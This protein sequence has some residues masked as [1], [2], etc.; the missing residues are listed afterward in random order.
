MGGSAG[1]WEHLLRVMHALNYARRAKKPV[2]MSVL[3][4]Q[5]SVGL[6]VAAHSLVSFIIRA[7]FV[8]HFDAS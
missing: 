5:R 4:T 3:Q 2:F 8:P 6:C 1:L 7:L